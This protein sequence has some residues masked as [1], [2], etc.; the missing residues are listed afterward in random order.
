MDVGDFEFGGSGVFSAELRRAWLPSRWFGQGDGLE[1]RA[2]RVIS[3]NA[4]NIV[5]TSREMEGQERLRR[6]KE[7]P[8]GQGWTRRGGDCHQACDEDY[9]GVAIGNRSGLWAFRLTL[10]IRVEDSISFL[11][12]PKA[13]RPISSTKIQ[14]RTPPKFPS[15]ASFTGRS[16][17]TACVAWQRGNLFYKSSWRWML[18]R[19]LLGRTTG[20]ILIESVIDGPA[21]LNIHENRKPELAGNPTFRESPLVELSLKGKR[22]SSHTGIVVVLVGLKVLVGFIIGLA[23]AKVVYRSRLTRARALRASLVAGVVFVLISGAAGWADAHAA[24]SNGQRVGFA[25]W[26]EDLRLRNAIAGNET[27]LCVMASIGMAALANIG[28]KDRGL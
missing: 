17:F 23:T 9:N 14:I 1:R 5:G 21:P 2:R 10:T 6:A 22:C 15:K 13:M 19:Q 27:L 28:T 12:E 26:G 7:K 4:R 24:F 18:P 3:A 16:V 8:A 11:R 25:P 20:S